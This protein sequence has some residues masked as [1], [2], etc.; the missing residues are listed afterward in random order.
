MPKTPPSNADSCDAAT[1][2]RWVPANSGLRQMLAAAIIP[3]VAYFAA[4]MN[5]LFGSAAKDRTSILMYHRVTPHV[6]GISAPTINV[7]PRRF[8]KQLEGLLR[9]GYSFWSLETLVQ[10][11]EN[12]EMVPDKVTCVTFDDGYCNN[13]VN[14]LPIL[15]DLGIPATIFLATAYIDKDEPFPCDHWSVKNCEALPRTA[16]A[17]LSLDECRELMK[18]P[19][20]T[21]G[22][23]THTHQDFRHRP[24]AFE[25]DMRLCLEYLRTELGIENPL[26]AFPYGIPRFGFNAS[27]LQRV[28]KQL[29]VRCALSTGPH[30]NDI[31]E[32]PF[33]WGRF[34]A[35]SWN[36]GATLAGMLSGWY[37]WA[38]QLRT[39]IRAE[40]SKIRAIT[41]HKIE[42]TI[43]A[44]D[45]TG[46]Y[47]SDPAELP[48]ISIIVPTYN[49]A[50]WLGEA[51]ESLEAQ[52]TE[53]LFTYDIV[54]IDNASS[55]NTKEVVECRA[56]TSDISILYCHSVP[57]GDAPTRNE[58]LRNSESDWIAFF[59][60]DQLATPHWLSG[61]FK[62]TRDCHSKIVGG[63]VLLDLPA[64]ELEW[65]GPIC[66]RALRELDFYSRLHPYVGKDLPGTG[67]TMVARELFDELGNFDESMTTGGSDSDFFIRAY[68][69]GHSLWFTPDAPIRHRIGRDRLEPEFFR[70]DS[71]S[72]GAGHAAHFEYREAGWSGLFATCGIRL[73]HAMFYVAPAYLWALLLR[74]S[75]TALGRRTQLW[76][77]EGYLRKTLNVLAPR[78]FEQKAFFDSLE[79]RNGRTIVKTPD[80]KSSDEHD[81]KDS[82]SLGNEPPNE[83]PVAETPTATSEVEV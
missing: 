74:D 18:H 31:R 2:N 19:L 54:V 17:P 48:T 78:L 37:S 77:T 13:L 8:R 10:C 29:G 40:R 14:A 32:T 1:V 43:P 26:F 24:E 44:L 69:A 6:K 68:E 75:G 35:F 71:L 9:R 15:E 27:S 81:K 51:L 7:T 58:G 83:S 34:N 50:S 49:R 47:E 65:L 82:K 63:P 42:L 3:M 55:D 16:Y 5:R 61:L 20:I 30:V 80:S 76:R 59:D 22:A 12:R 38:D 21:L 53:G 36:T 45:G 79:F 4:A 28:A 41:R 23:H 67:N 60:D 73:I 33:E 46:N 11:H 66:R 70:W 25:E 62:A 72:G 39:R 52:Q 57:P 56:A 64:D